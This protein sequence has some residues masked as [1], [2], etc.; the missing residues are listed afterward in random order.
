MFFALLKIPIVFLI[1]FF[2]SLCFSVEA[3]QGHYCYTYG[4]KE[5]LKEAKELTRT[6]AIRNAI[7]SYRVYIE[8]ASSVKNFVLTGDIIQIL[9]SGYLKN[10]KVLE[11]KEEGR[12]VCETI[13]AT[14]SPQE[15]EKVVRREATKKTVKI[16]EKGLDNNGYLKI[17]SVSDKTHDFTNPDTKKD[18]KITS[19]QAKVK[20]LK[21]IMSDSEYCTLFIAYFDADGNESSTDKK[22]LVDS[23]FR[24]NRDTGEWLYPGEIRLFGFAWQ[25]ESRPYKIWLYNDKHGPKDSNIHQGKKKK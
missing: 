10:I 13:E 12:T 3:I 23:S 24:S 11:H 7:E 14:V 19:V 15:I 16:E 22:R 9:S 18:Y 8:S 25:G 6:L 4:D 5:S 21:K 17:L 20:I 1:L 2:P